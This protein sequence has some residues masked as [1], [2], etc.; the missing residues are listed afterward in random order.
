[1]DLSMPF[2]L[3]PAQRAEVAC[4]GQPVLKAGVASKPGQ[5]VQGLAEPKLGISKEWKIH[6]LSRQTVPVL[7]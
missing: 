2:G 4:E 3:T 7:S 1:M 6:S 5:V